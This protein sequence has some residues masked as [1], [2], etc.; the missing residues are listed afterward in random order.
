LIRQVL[1]ANAI[2][3]LQYAVGSLVPLLLVPHI[4]GVIG[5]AEYGSLAVLLA[6][7]NYGAGVVQYAFYLTGPKRIA[8][9][10]A[11]DSPAS[12]FAD[13]TLAKF[14]LLCIVLPLTAAL[15]LVLPPVGSASSIARGLLFVMPMAA[16]LNS[17]W[18]LQTQGR[19][20]SVCLLAIAGS[21]LTL[22]IGFGLI[23][24]GSA[25][26]VDFT[27]VASAFGT[28]FSG[29]GTFALALASIK[30]QEHGWKITKAFDA[31]KEGRPLFLSAFV[32]MFYSMSGPIV[33]NYLLDARAA[34]AYSVTERVMNALIAAATLT[35][36]A[37]YPRLAIAYVNDR[38]GYWRTLKFVLAAYLGVTVAA[39]VLAWILREP[40]VRF[41]YGEA[42]GD[43]DVLF[44]FGL[45]WLVLGIFGTT[46]TGYLT[47]SG[48]GAEV[49]PLTLKILIACAAMG[50][51]GVLLFGN[52][53]WLAALVLSQGLV[54]HCGFKHWRREHGG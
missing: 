10:A 34:G 53:G 18:F 23:T 8:H 21:L 11:D 14:F 15:M 26:A 4:V 43:H 5:L 40:I 51:P 9:L 54:L 52:A 29:I 50:V 36:T 1:Q 44:F 16:A 42:G 33:V 24:R 49:W 20:L 22:I 7:G 2:L 3:L 30:G 25:R 48:R 41:M 31:L 47:V 27:V 19:F 38:A 28:V 39:A 46:L 32:S 6:W 37:A 45:A 12:A 17:V 35:Y 13:V